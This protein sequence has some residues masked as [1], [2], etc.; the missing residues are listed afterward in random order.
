MPEGLG[1]RLAIENSF[2]ILLAVGAAVADLEPLMIVLVLAIGWFLVVLVELMAWRARPQYAIQAATGSPAPFEL[3]PLAE[4]PYGGAPPEYAA[5]SLA[6]P[7]PEFPP[8]PVETVE[9]VQPAAEPAPRQGGADYEF[10]FSRPEPADPEPPSDGETAVRPPPAEPEM[11][12]F[13][14]PEHERR[15]VRLEPLQPR[16]RGGL[17][18]RRS[19]RPPEPPREAHEEQ[20]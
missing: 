10:A 11:T 20:E 3:P 16:P 4:G 15:R 8:A 5:G 9:P 6:E 19:R 12:L 7:P 13:H 1:P 2:L 17:F 18:R 14:A